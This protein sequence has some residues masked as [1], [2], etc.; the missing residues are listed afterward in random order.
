VEKS[1]D[2]KTLKKTDTYFFLLVG[3]RIV[4]IIYSDALSFGGR[5]GGI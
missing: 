3:M 2:K 5:Y 4:S 1:Q